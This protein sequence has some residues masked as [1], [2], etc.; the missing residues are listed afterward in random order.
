M[1]K[2]KDFVFKRFSVAQTQATHKVGTDGVLVGAW[3]NVLNCK[4]ILDVGTGSGLIALMLAQ[5]TPSSVVIDGIDIQEADALQAKE[6]ITR[7]AWSDRISIHHTSLQSFAPVYKY[8]LIVSNPPY[9]INS[10]KPPKDNRSTVRHTETLPFA[11]LIRFAKE[12]LSSVGRL[13]VILPT[14]EAQLFSTIA[15]NDGFHLIRK[16]EFRSRAHKE[17]ER[18]LMECSFE[19]R[20]LD[21]ES[22]V[23]HGEGEEWSEAY[24]ELTKD[25][26]IKI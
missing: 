18:W 4:R 2:P 3:V 12:H 1:K 9:F 23:L 13:A 22:L 14:V 19:K 10:Y 6:N 5:R 25:F 21:S 11:D 7:S 17:I 20:V 16:C 15:G 24:K 26:Y 8:D